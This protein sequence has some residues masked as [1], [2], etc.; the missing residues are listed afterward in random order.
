M[1]AILS[2][3][4][5]KEVPLDPARVANA[6]DLLREKSV[7][8]HTIAPILAN[9]VRSKQRGGTINETALRIAEIL[10]IN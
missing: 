8:G 5:N 2:R 10:R 9:Y 7:L 6:P 3:T 4:L 1:E